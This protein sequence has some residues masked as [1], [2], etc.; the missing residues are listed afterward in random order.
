ME[1]TLSGVSQDV[2]PDAPCIESLFRLSVEYGNPTARKLCDVI[3]PSL[4]DF[5]DKLKAS[6]GNGRLDLHGGNIMYRKDGSVCV[7][8]PVCHRSTL[9]HKRLRSRDFCPSSTLH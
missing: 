8:D 1:Y 3:S 4:G 6:F 7:T 9:Q 5:G 2:Q